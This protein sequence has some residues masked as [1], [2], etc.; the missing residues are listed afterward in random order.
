MHD[1]ASLTRMELVEALLPP[2]PSGCDEEEALTGPSAALPE[3]NPS[4][5][6]SPQGLNRRQ[7]R[8]AALNLISATTGTSTVAVPLILFTLGLGP[9][10]IF[11]VC[12]SALGVL[13]NHILSCESHASG[14]G[15]YEEL[16]HARVGRW[17]GLAAAASMI[18]NGFGKIVIWI[19]ISTD[20]MLGKL[21]HH[22]GLLPELLSH[23]GFIVDPGAWFLQR[24]AWSVILG[25]TAIPAVSFG[26][27]QS[28]TWVSSLGDVAVGAMAVC[29]VALAVVAGYEGRAFPLDWLPSGEAVGVS[30]M[31]LWLRAG[32]MLPILLSTTFNQAAILTVT[33]EVEPYRQA[34]VDDACV[35]ANMSTVVIKLVLGAANIALFGAA[36]QADVLLNFSSKGLKPFLAPGKALLVSAVVRLAFL[37]KGVASFPLYLLPLQGNFWAAIEGRQGARRHIEKPWSY[38]LFNYIT[39]AACA[40]CAA[41]IGDIERPLKVVGA[42]AVGYLAYFAPALLVL[43]PESRWKPGVRGFAWLM[44]AVG[45][46]QAFLGIWGAVAL[47]H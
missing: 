15:T 14:K 22:H 24:W 29:S 47:Q 32:S 33:K 9:A 23:A 2:C 35:A 39:V 10:L 38:A 28:V 44:V 3:P 43:R 20:V 13:A 19:I 25:V 41:A 46:V 18:F 40:A 30:G 26:S 42:S 45:V 8:E 21:P 17:A 5:N 34:S 31:A 1:D 6:H 4:P 27:L 37:A 7:T 11:F 36:L 12:Q 16:M